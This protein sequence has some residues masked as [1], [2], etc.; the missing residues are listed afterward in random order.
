MGHNRAGEGD[1]LSASAEQ[2]AG[3]GQEPARW[4]R[5]TEATMLHTLKIFTQLHIVNHS[6][7]KHSYRWLSVLLPK[8]KKAVSHDKPF[9][10]QYIL[11]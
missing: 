7:S 6:F 1:L 11:Y 8:F 3:Q 9:S 5:D 10:F 2:S 4:A